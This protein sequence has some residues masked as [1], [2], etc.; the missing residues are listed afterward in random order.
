MAK[1]AAAWTLMPSRAA[2]F[3]APMTEVYAGFTAITSMPAR[4]A[5]AR[6]IESKSL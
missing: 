2:W 1:A 4:K 6:N 3:T 5:A